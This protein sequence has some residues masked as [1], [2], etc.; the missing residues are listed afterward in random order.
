MLLE[1]WP[2]HVQEGVGFAAATRSTDIAAA[3]H[4]GRLLLGPL[5]L[6]VFS[7]L[8]LPGPPVA[9]ANH[10][11]RSLGVPACTGNAADANCFRTDGPVAPDVCIR[12]DPD[13]VSCLETVPNYAYPSTVLSADPQ[14]AH[15]NLNG[16]HSC[17]ASDPTCVP[18]GIHTQEQIDWSQVEGA[19]FLVVS[20][21]KRRDVD[22]AVNIFVD[23]S[24]G[25]DQTGW[26]TRESPLRS[27]RAGLKRWLMPGHCYPYCGSSALS[28][29]GTIHVSPGVYSGADNREIQL[30]V[31][32]GISVTV[33]VDAVFQGGERGISTSRDPGVDV[34]IEGS[35]YWL[36][37]SGGG[38]LS[39]LSMS[40]RNT[41]SDA[42]ITDMSTKLVTDLHFPHGRYGQVLK[43][44]DSNGAVVASPN[45]DIAVDDRFFG[46]DYD[47]DGSKGCTI[48]R[49]THGFDPRYYGPLAAGASACTTCS[50][51]APIP[52]AGLAHN[53]LWQRGL[54]AVVT[55]AGMGCANGGMLTAVHASG[56]RGSGFSATFTVADGAISVIAVT[57]HGSGYE[58]VE[59]VSI[60]IEVGGD[61]CKDLV[62]LPYLVYAADTTSAGFE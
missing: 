41:S 11:G 50:V 20:G 5:I 40:V 21:A 15:V 35:G 48:V 13:S 1:K 62:F 42:I 51:P 30:L 45:W 52:G 59:G 37:A 33:K 31:N 53:S 56:V 24:R 46:K 28:R 19:E 38:T 61:G 26:G 17:D 10:P 27:L 44:V 34:R 16:M 4:R 23:A 6:F 36:K 2:G 54:G 25:N 60:R 12:R 49:R 43:S 22:S 14:S 29:S 57:D 47:C 58:S 8:F 39:L 32:S 3:V 18:G 9:G 55:H 7:L